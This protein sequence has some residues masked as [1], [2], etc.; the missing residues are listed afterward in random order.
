MK[1]VNETDKF[2]MFQKIKNEN[3]KTRFRLY[4]G[5][6]FQLVKSLTGYQR[7]FRGEGN[8]EQ[9][10][11]EQHADYRKESWE[12]GKEL[13]IDGKAIVPHRFN[14]FSGCVRFIFSKLGNCPAD[15][16]S[17]DQVEMKWLK[18]CFNSSVIYGESEEKGKFWG[19]DFKSFYP[20][21][22]ANRSQVKLYIPLRRGEE[23]TLTELPKTL[24]HGYYR[25]KITCTDPRAR[26]VFSFSPANVYSRRSYNHAM[27]MKHGGGFKDTMNIELICDGKPNA[28]IYKKEDV[29]E[30]GPIFDKWEKTMMDLREKLPG[31]KLAKRLCSSLYSCLAETY[32]R[33]VDLDD[34]ETQDDLIMKGWRLEKVGADKVTMCNY[35][36]HH[37]LGM[38][39]ITWVTARARYRMWQVFKDRI[40]DIRRVYV[41]SVVLTKPIP[42]KKLNRI[43]I[44]KP[45]PTISGYLQ[46]DKTWQPTRLSFEEES[47][48]DTA[49]IEE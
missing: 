45:D 32:R 25:L 22:M 38:R 16:E 41:D 11:K 35:C 39:L 4:D 31:N 36:H 14:K 18:Q 19:Y 5:E 33:K 47:E 6:T 27:E 3:G 44:L 30:T 28:Y 20:R 15:M 43:Y 48:V 24:D 2:Y 46:L 21:M 8:T 26:R 7:C 23:K 37:P 9:K 49:H 12:V 13:K 42:E 29:V 10:L 1:S 40:D 34:E 17:P